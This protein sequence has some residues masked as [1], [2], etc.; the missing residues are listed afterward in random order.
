MKKTRSFEKFIGTIWFRRLSGATPNDWRS[1]NENKNT[2]AVGE[3][4]KNKK[5]TDKSHKLER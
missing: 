3:E 1:R 4:T 2:K 5:I